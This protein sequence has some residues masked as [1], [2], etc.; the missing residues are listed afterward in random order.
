MIDS[1]NVVG[2]GIWL[3]E[4]DSAAGSEQPVWIV[5]DSANP[6][7]CTDP[8]LVLPSIKHISLIDVTCSSAGL[9]SL[10]STLLTL[11]HEVK[12]AL[13]RC[14]ISSRVEGAL[15]R[16]CLFAAITTDVNNTFS[17][18]LESDHCPGLWEALHGQSIKCL[19]LSGLNA[20]LKN[21]NAESLLKSVQSLP[22]LETLNIKVNVNAY[23]SPNLWETL[24]SL[25]IKRV[26]LIINSVWCGLIVHNASMLSQA[27]LSNNTETICMYLNAQP[28]KI[29]AMHG[30]P[31][32]SLS[33][34]GSGESLDIIHVSSL[35]KMLSSLKQLKNVGV[36]VNN[37]NP[38]LWEAFHGL[39][40][41]CLS[42][43][44]RDLRVNHVS[45]FSQLLSSLAQ[46]EM[47]N[48]KVNF[49]SPGFLDALHGLNIKS[50]SL[51]G[52]RGGLTGLDERVG[53][54][55]DETLVSAIQI[56]ETAGH[57]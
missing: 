38:G 25:N 22:Q 4:S 49:D 42:L 18:H 27:L 12:C 14:D 31:I 5:L 48:V 23:I 29:E 36:F 21:Q 56:A 3:K 33:L 19:S 15:S 34:F 10:F 47:L 44:N 37:E 43:T 28:C 16:F 39:N 55:T 30:L 26:I 17:L 54:A 11:D 32:E 8:P 40:I 24:N 1:L 51:N 35:Y 46:L 41:K 50:L 20:K 57:A 9:H 52:L 45:S 6:A 53:S 7:Q 13:M 2:N